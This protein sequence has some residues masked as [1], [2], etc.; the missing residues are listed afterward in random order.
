MPGLDGVAGSRRW[1]PS[2]MTTVALILGAALATWIIVVIRMRGMDAGP[3]T[4]LGSLGWYVGIWVTM[5]AAM[6]LPSVAPMVL[7]FHRVSTER[8]RRG[9][10]FVPTWVFVGA[11]FAVWAVYGLAA[12]GLYRLLVHSTGGFFDWDRGGRWVAGAAIALAGVYELTPLKSVCL[13]HCRS[14]LHY[15]MGSWRNG[16]GGAVRMG[17]EHGA[18]CVGCCW[19]LM[20]VLFA[21]GVMSLT[22]MIVVAALIFAQKVLPHGEVLTKAFAVAFISI[23]VWV[24]AAPGTVPGLTLPTSDGANR[25]RARMMH[26]QPGGMQMQQSQ[27][28]QQHGMK[29]QP[30]MKPMT[31]TSMQPG[32]T[33]EEQMGTG[34]GP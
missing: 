7:V 23:G 1:S 25:A 6:M 33:T 31:T 34:M 14:P 4:D 19:G 8:A 11:Y 15:V 17:A 29:Q 5:M 21:L 13:K 32:M 26:M 16:W 12:F 10:S 9:Q 24:A 27:Q 20:L 28:M 30:A 18:Y 22:W 3:G 2:Q